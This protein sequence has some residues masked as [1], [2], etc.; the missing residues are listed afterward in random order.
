MQAKN[1]AAQAQF[2]GKIAIDFR[3]FQKIL[4]IPIIFSLPNRENT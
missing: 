3:S 1:Y 2:D 4:K